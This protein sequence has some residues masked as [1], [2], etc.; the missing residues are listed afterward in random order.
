MRLAI[1]KGI[2]IKAQV[3]SFPSYQVMQ[4]SYLNLVL[5]ACVLYIFKLASG[6]KIVQSGQ[7]I[8][9]ICICVKFWHTLVFC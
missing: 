4:M 7:N 6:L 3:Y 8:F 1:Q 2:Y 9:C 5:Q